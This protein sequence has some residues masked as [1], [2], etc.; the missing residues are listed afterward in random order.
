MRDGRGEKHG[1]YDEGKGHERSL[2]GDFSPGLERSPMEKIGKE[3]VSD[4][5]GSPGA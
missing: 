5:S 4:S 2:K 1:K 3:F